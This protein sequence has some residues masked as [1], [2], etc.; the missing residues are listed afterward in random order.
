MEKKATIRKVVVRNRRAL[1]A[2]KESIASR[3]AIGQRELEHARSSGLLDEL[4]KANK[5][6]STQQ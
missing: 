5:K 3:A 2:I 4:L 6:S 1:D